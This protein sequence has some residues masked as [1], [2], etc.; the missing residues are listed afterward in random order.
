MCDILLQ[1]LSSIEF[2]PDY[3]P[4]AQV[5]DIATAFQAFFESQRIQMQ[6]GYALSLIHI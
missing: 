3:D 5:I 6:S 4:E 1:V 2:D